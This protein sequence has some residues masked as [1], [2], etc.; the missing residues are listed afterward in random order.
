MRVDI[1][2]KYSYSSA[3]IMEEKE[4][5]PIMEEKKDN[6][7][8]TNKVVISDKDREKIDRGYAYCMEYFKKLN[9]K[10]V[11]GVWEYLKLINKKLDKTP[12]FD[13]LPKKYGRVAVLKFFGDLKNNTNDAYYY[14]E[15]IYEDF[16]AI[17]HIIIGM[18]LMQDEYNRY[19]PNYTPKIK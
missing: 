6:T 10:Q 5:A 18:L 19:N 1:K 17:W 2:P 13:L 7:T 4:K 9:S 3:P 15:L 12:K 16:M 14:P 8:K 11:D